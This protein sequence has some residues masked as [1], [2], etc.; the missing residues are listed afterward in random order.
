MNS[1]S[2]SETKYLAH[3]TVKKV[4]EL[5]LKLYSYTQHLRRVNKKI[6]IKIHLK[7]NAHL[8]LLLI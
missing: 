8:R 2:L 4:K 6:C 5:M 3:Q 7:L 1:Q